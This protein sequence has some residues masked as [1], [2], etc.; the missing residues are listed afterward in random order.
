MERP[1]LGQGR[2]HGQPQQ[3]LECLDSGVMDAVLQPAAQAVLGVATVNVHPTC[4][5]AQGAASRLAVK[6]QVAA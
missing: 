3:A 5:G 6:A 2:T 4:G 1:L